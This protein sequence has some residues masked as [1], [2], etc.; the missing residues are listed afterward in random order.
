MDRCRNPDICLTQAL[1]AALSRPCPPLVNKELPIFTTT[2]LTLVKSF[3]VT[4]FPPFC[5]QK[6]HDGKH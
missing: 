6:I 3:L 1:I 4:I 5:F 2:R